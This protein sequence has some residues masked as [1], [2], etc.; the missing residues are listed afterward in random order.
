MAGMLSV[1]AHKHTT[2]SQNAT[3]YCLAFD[4]PKTSYNREKHVL[5]MTATA[6]DSVRRSGRATKGQHHKKDEEIE[7]VTPK[8]G[9]KGNKAKK[10]ASTEAT[11]PAEDDE[12]ALI[13]CICGVIEDED[14]AE[15]T[16]ICCDRCTAWQHNDCMEITEDPN[17]MPEQYFCE[18]CKPEDH[19]GL[20]AKIA[21]GEKPWEERARQREMEAAER[22]AR[23][24]KGGKRGRR[25]RP[26]EAKVEKVE[27][28]ETVKGVNG[29]ARATK[30]VASPTQPSQQVP[31]VATPQPKQIPSQTPQATPHPPPIKATAPPPAPEPISKRMTPEV[32]LKK[33]S[34]PEAGQKRKL[35][36]DTPSSEAK[37]AEPVSCKILQQS[38][39]STDFFQEPAQKMRKVSTPTENKSS[40]QRRKSSTAPVPQGDTV[41][42]DTPSQIGLVESVAELQHPSRNKSAAALVKL[43]VDQTKQANKQGTYTP[44]SNKTVDD[45]GRQLGLLVEYALYMNYWD[46]APNPREQYAIVFRQILHNVKANS[47]LRDRLLVGDLS[48][49]ELSKMSSEDMASKE[50]KEMTAE[51]KKMTEKQHLLVKDEGPRIRRT[52]KGE[53]LIDDG[54][55]HALPS[56][57]VYTDAVAP[58]RRDTDA[59]EAMAKR[60]ISPG[61]MSP[62]DGNAVELP[63][64]LSTSGFVSSPTTSRPPVLET[65]TARPAVHNQRKSS[66][67]FDIQ[68][69]WSSVDS[70]SE[71][72]HR[73]SRTFAPPS[74]TTAAPIH[75]TTQHV[76]HYQPK[77]PLQIQTDQEIDKLLKDEEEPED[78]EPYSPTDIPTSD[79]WHGTV[80]M[81]SVG[82]FAG[83]ARWVAGA[84]LGLHAQLPWA[85]VMP[86]NLLIEGRIAIDKANLYLCG[87]EW[88][89]TTDLAIVAISPD[90]EDDKQEF[91]KL[92]TYFT[93][94]ERYGVITKPPNVPRLRDVYLVPLEAGTG[95]KPDFLELLE[96]CIVEEDR[97][98]RVLL[99]AF[100][101]KTKNSEAAGDATA[102]PRQPDAGVTLGSPVSA[103]QRRQ[104]MNM[105]GN[106]QMSPVVPHFPGQQG[107]PMDGVMYN[108]S[109][110]QR[111]GQAFSPPTSYQQTMPPYNAYPTP[112]QSQT[113]APPPPQQPFGIDAARLVLGELSQCPT[114]TMLLNHAPTTGVEEFIVVREA[115]ETNPASRTE[116]H[117]LLELLKKKGE[118]RAAAMR[119]G[120]GQ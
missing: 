46:P 49:D 92:F 85:S 20:L 111:H 35:R 57:P 2:I 4:H 33:K 45:V 25:G 93:S 9:A 18:Q 11:P 74:T 112:H 72:N 8:R 86:P 5:T 110:A 21:R 32:P 79:V 37:V 7:A 104:S 53:E 117:V 116:F 94:R 78:E 14:D 44:P 87:L 15:R 102:T 60:D 109:P 52:H 42:K 95:S 6:D 12:D 69:V 114:V 75:P 67:T 99:V 27:K 118:D 65:K 55:S 83:T 16:M 77:A 76:P 90:S 89:K 115:F 26:S 62:G 106:Q 34:T 39:N 84:N 88:S 119:A 64:E 97:P 24:R 29:D 73:N 107:T 47:A 51:M 108:G 100:V 120:N 101:A 81:S 1:T 48:A 22:K 56:A 63:A 58:R 61:P 23:R 91:D 66:S 40:T 82:T 31:P 28:V 68:N 41:P 3:A 105:G 38:I 96:D 98:S 17:E 10:Q 54:S 70:P 113:Q 50:L 36:V 30:A 103:V 19:Q 59:E 80:S 71:S 43:F 13:R